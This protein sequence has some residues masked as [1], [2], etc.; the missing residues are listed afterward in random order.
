M[1]PHYIFTRVCPHKS[2]VYV[3]RR[4]TALTY[5][6]TQEYM[7]IQSTRIKSFT[8]YISLYTKSVYRMQSVLTLPASCH[9]CTHVAKHCADKPS[10]ACLRS[11]NGFI[12]NKRR[13]S[14]LYKEASIRQ[15]ALYLRKE[16]CLSANEPCIF[17]QESCTSVQ[18]KC[19]ADTHID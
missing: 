18:K 1:Y 9:T 17:A 2:P 12:L 10:C 8:A 14:A 6:H 7:Y 16:P 15:R 5:T 19:R 13:K 11:L 4:N 3:H